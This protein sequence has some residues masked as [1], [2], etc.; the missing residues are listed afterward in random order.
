MSAGGRGRGPAERGLKGATARRME[1]PVCEAGV[2]VILGRLD[3]IR[4]SGRGWRADCPV[5]HRSRGTLSIAEGDD[6][7][8]LLHC[9]VGCSAADVLTA[10]GLTLPD[11]FP[12]RMPPATPEARRELRRRAKESSWSAALCVLAREAAVVLAASATL[13]R[14]HVLRDEDHGRLALAERR[15]HAARE[16]LR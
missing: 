16:V 13:L 14:G 11:L 1:G 7:R 6:G 15:I 4:E 8:V 12:E 2:E 5:G 3:G 10:L 9:F